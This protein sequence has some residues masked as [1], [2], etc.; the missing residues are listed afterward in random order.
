MKNA[1]RKFASSSMLSYERTRDKKYW[2][3]Q[4]FQK[5]SPYSLQHK[6]DLSSF[7][8]ILKVIARE[9]SITS[10]KKADRT[11]GSRTSGNSIEFFRCRKA[12]SPLKDTYTQ[13]LFTRA[14]FSGYSNFSNSGEIVPQYDYFCSKICVHT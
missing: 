12:N 11:K 3:S 10:V 8:R 7:V 6:E 13:T 9:R 2:L 4:I 14:C 5:T 1:R